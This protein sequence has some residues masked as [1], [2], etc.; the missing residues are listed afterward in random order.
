MGTNL[1]LRFIAYLFLDVDFQIPSY[2]RAQ[3]Q[4]EYGIS[5]QDFWTENELVVIREIE[6]AFAACDETNKARLKKY[7]CENLI[8][9][10]E[11]MKRELGELDGAP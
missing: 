11:S 4:S 1:S 3:R 8:E 7:Y 6:E 2:E 9:L 5:R 10:I